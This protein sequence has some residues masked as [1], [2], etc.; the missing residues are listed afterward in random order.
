MIQKP[1]E[2][3]DAMIILQ[4]D[5]GVGK[6]LL[7]LFC[8]AMIGSNLYLS[9]ANINL[10]FKNFNKH[11]SNKLLTRLNELSDKGDNIDK[12]E[13][14]KEKITAVSISV[15]PKGFDAYTIRHFSRY[16]AFTNTENVVNVEHTDR[17]FFM[18]KCLST[19]ANNKKYFE[20]IMKEVKS[21]EMIQSAFKYYS[22]KDIS[23]FS[24]REFPTTTLKENQKISSLPYSLKYFYYFFEDKQNEVVKKHIDDLYA[25]FCSWCIKMGNK[26]IT[27]RLNFVRDMK[28]LGIETKRIRINKQLKDGIHIT[29]DDLQ[30]KFKIYMKNDTFTIHKHDVEDNT[31]L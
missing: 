1:F 27:V 4:S 12:H 9:I 26:H 14:L 23:H 13:L 29:F 19:M 2:Q 20:P 11:H 21:L 10:F 16:F 6:D 17:R 3:A 5:Q 30:E 8:E 25:D 28:N 15:E 31:I 18:I 24:T 7:M 22:T